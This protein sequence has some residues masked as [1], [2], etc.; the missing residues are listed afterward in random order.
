MTTGLMQTLRDGGHSLV[1]AKDGDTHTYDGPGVSDLLR[2]VAEGGEPLRDA[3]VA[4]K[5]VGKAAAALMVAGGISTLDAG[6]ASSPAIALLKRYSIPV[7]CQRVTPYIVNRK[8]TGM[9]PLELRCMDCATAD[10]CIA[11]I[12]AFLDNKK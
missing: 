11:R 5:V 7:R 3:A 2:L 4:D 8:G 9:C 1:V 6:V 12:H 10:E